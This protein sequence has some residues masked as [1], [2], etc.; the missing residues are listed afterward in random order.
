M[1]YRSTFIT[2]HWGFKFSELFVDKY[3]DRY[4]F[5]SDNSLPI[6][7]KIEFKRFWDNLEDDIVNEL[8]FQNS[9]HRIFG[10]WLHEDGQIDRI[11]FTKEGVFDYEEWMVNN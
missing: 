11:V 4:N 7:S 5:G 9:N 10:V 6:S 2:D 1:G 3:K 8:K